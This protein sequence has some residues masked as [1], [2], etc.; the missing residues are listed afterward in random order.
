MNNR[1]YAIDVLRCLA[2]VGMVLSGQIFWHPELPAWLFHAQIPPPDF[3]FNP[4]VPGI[5]WVD[6][7]FPFFLFSMG[8]A[9]PLALRRK[10]EQGVAT[11]KIAWDTVKRWALLSLF[12]IALANTRSLPI[13]M[14]PVVRS[15]MFIGV[16]GLFFAMFVRLKN[17]S[18]HANNILNI[19]GAA[20]VIGVMLIYRFALGM[21]VSIERCDIIIMILANMALIGTLVWWFTKDNLPARFAVIAL[22]AAIK[23][24]VDVDG[25]WNQALWQWSPVQWLYKA[26]YIKYLCIVLPGSI[27]GDMI[28]RWI[29]NPH[30]KGLNRDIPSSPKAALWAV[31]V[32]TVLFAVNMWG[33]FTRHLVEN[34]ILSGTLGVAAWLLLKKGMTPTERLHRKIFTLALFWLLLGLALEAYEGGIKKDYATL[35]YFFVTSA[36]ASFVVIVVSS[37]I[38]YYRV[39]LNFLVRCGQNPMIAYTASAYLVVPTLII[40]HLNWVLQWMV[41]TS[42]WLCVAR[43]ATVTLLMMVVTVAFTRKGIFWRT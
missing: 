43:G 40:V 6:L 18:A 14:S 35:S 26:E 41:D 17:L 25:S 37:L 4:Q 34:L 39:N 31:V 16:W 10:I 9:F 22:L 13:D 2:I 11:R 19:C 20:A 29:N 24:S 12:A 15:L 5:T 8:A 38:N 21:N 7:V 3:T 36:L 23:I 28:Y 33:L 32:L 30:R 1:A 42:P 27:A